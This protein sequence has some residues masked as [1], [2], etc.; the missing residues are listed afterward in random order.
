[1]DENDIILKLHKGGFA[2]YSPLTLMCGRGGIGRRAA[3]RS[4][5]GNTRGSSSL[6]GRTNY[7]VVTLALFYHN[8]H[9]LRSPSK[10][11]MFRDRDHGKNFTMTD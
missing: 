1:M 4:L 7:C 5:W 9:Q 10:Y 8:A 3:L 11:I 2:G 6:L